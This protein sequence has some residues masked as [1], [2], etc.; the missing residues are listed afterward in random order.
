MTAVVGT[1]LERSGGGGSATFTAPTGVT[2]TMVGLFVLGTATNVDPVSVLSSP[3]VTFTQI[4]KR[5][6]G[7]MYVTVI[8]ATGLV[9]AATIT[10]SQTTT[11]TTYIAHD[12]QDVYDYTTASLSAAVRGSSVS[13]CVTGSIT[14]ASG[15]TVAVVS[16]ERTTATGTTVSSAVSSGS[17]TVTQIEYGESAGT[18]AVS[19]YRGVFTASAAAARTVTVTYNSGSGNG[20]AAAVLTT[21]I[22]PANP[23]YVAHYTS[24]TDT[25]A[26][27]K[28]YY[29]SATDTLATPLEVRAM[30]SG[31]ASVTTMLATAGFACA[32]RG[33]SVD[34]PEMSLH[35]YTQSAFWGVGAIEFS[36]H[37][38]SDGVWFGLH[39]DTL[40]RTSGT[41][42]V[43]ASALTWA[44]ISSTYSISAN[45]PSG[46]TAKPYL[47]LADLLT[48]YG[49]SHVIFIDLKSQTSF[50]TE[51]LDILSAFYGSDA[52][53]A[54]R[55]VIKNYG[56]GGTSL[57]TAA[58]ARGFQ[59]W[60]YFYQADSA[61]YSADVGKWSFLGLDYNADA[62]TWT[63]FRTFTGAKKIMAHILPSAASLTTAIARSAD[64]Y[65]V[66]GVAEALTRT[67][68]T[69]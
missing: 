36:A 32:H 45:L 20:Y 62:A 66:S 29:T 40:D 47:L 63:N 18:T 60:G 14:P 2:S 23:G 61:S 21:P 57:N 37:R 4:D 8:K 51:I 68:S 53:A 55:V 33:G 10:L 6:A 59:T 7:N 67:A 1:A 13:T 38:T 65:M 3:G 12:Y 58:Q 64:G 42:S 34:W 41:S 69:V 54:A 48:A 44:T 16:L 22:V 39:D 49:N 5:A 9:A 52:A 30:P 43:T 56:V 25:L 46:Q 50:I 24:A 15:Q 35:A 19:I 17:E 27:G 31:Y 28:L 11:V 26:T